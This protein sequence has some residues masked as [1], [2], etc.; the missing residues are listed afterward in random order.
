MHKPG[1][2][3]EA[4]T[5]YIE[6]TEWDQKFIEIDGEEKPLKW[7]I[8]QLWNCTDVMPGSA[9]DAIDL[10]RGSTYARAVRKLLSE[11]DFLD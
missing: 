1:F 9:C 3:R 7:L 8:G 6:F 5:D 4:F 10:S 11:L 2:L